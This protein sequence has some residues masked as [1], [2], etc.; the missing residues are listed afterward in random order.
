MPRK[1][2]TLDTQGPSGSTYLDIALLSLLII[3]LA[4]GLFPVRWQVLCK[5]GRSNPLCPRSETPAVTIPPAPTST[6]TPA[7]YTNTPTTTPTTVKATEKPAGGPIIAPPAPTPTTVTPGPKVTEAPPIATSSLRLT[8]TITMAKDKVITYALTIR[9]EGPTNPITAILVSAFNPGEGILSVTG[10]GCGPF[11][12]GLVTCTVDQVRMDTPYSLVL[13]ANVNP[14]YSGTITNTITVTGTRKAINTNLN[15]SKITVVTIESPVIFPAYAK[16]IYVQ[17]NHSTHELGL[18]T[19]GGWVI[20]S[21]LHVH[22]AAPAWS[23]DGKSIAFFGEQGISELGGEYQKGNGIWIIDGQGNN[24]QQILQVDHVKNIA[25]SPDGTKL[26]FEIGQP[27]ITHEIRVVDSSSGYEISRFPGQQPAWSPDSQKLAIRNCTLGGGLCQV[28][29]D[30]GSEQL[31]TT[32]GT[33]SY[34]AWS[35]DGRYLAFTAQRDTS[36]EI[37][38]LRLADGEVRRLT[39]RSGSD[40]TP[41]FSQNGREIYLR[42]D[43]FGDWRITVLSLDTGEEHTV[44]RD[45]GPSIDWGLA[46]SAV[47]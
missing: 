21:A 19:S 3:V 17:S 7:Q 43:A 28:N 33:D 4:I 18:V 12:E 14:H 9:N 44:R 29:F 31:I 47:Y 30:G 24:A 11:S 16:V 37:Y 35:P 13:V 20:N 23:P 1:K 22:S 25:W 45:V 27:G 10:K 32:N 36:W 40:V 26:A 42:T 41:V 2:P 8:D 38:L 34:P 39:D 6:P 5:R 15:N 46:R